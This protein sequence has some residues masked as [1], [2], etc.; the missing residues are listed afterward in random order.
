MCPS[1]CFALKLAHRFCC[2]AAAH[3]RSGSGRGWATHMHCPRRGSICAHMTPEIKE[4]Q[5]TSKCAWMH[6]KCASGAKWRILNSSFV[7]QRRSMVW[8]YG[9]RKRLFGR[10]QVLMAAYDHT[11]F[12][13]FAIQVFITPAVPCRLC[14]SLR[15]L[16]IEL[17]LRQHCDVISIS[18]HHIACNVQQLVPDGERSAY[19]TNCKCR[20]KGSKALLH[21]GF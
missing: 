7:E 6:T 18:M 2:L 17:I 4:H 5:R 16:Q 10:W 11:L 14:R 3:S 13:M 1:V 8:L 19:D 15:V 21:M 9:N 12:P 20:L